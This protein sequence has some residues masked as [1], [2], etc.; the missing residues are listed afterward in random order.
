MITRRLWAG[1]AALAVLTAGVA[2]LASRPSAVPPAPPAV[3]FAPSLVGTTPD[4]EVRH[5]LTRELVIDEGLRELFDYYLATLGERPLEQ[6]VAEIERVLNA[7]LSPKAAAE[8]RALLSRYLVYRRALVALEQ[9]RTLAGSDLGALKRRLAAIRQL[10][11]RN[12]GAEVA[13]R[14]F[15][16]EDRFAEDMLARLA[17]RQNPNLNPAQRA[18]ALAELDRALPPEMLAARAALVQHQ[19]LAETVAAARARGADEAEVFRL[20]SAEVGPEAARRLAAVDAEERAW[21]TRIQA[22]LS[23]YHALRADK[24]LD[25]TARTQAIQA[26]RDARFS[27]DEQRRLAAYEPG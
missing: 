10:R 6:V 11:E 16:D 18:A 3:P 13:R 15:G 25:D 21:Q 19:Q 26:L 24:T 17:I 27:A 22:Y 1:G 4:G 5:S 2:W 20:R 14:L 23:D 7:R 9:D 12:F 8:A